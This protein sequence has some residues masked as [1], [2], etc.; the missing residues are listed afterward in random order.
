MLRLLSLKIKVEEENLEKKICEFLKINQRDL[1]H[2]NIIKKS[3]D[4]RRKD[5]IYFVY[6]L[7]VS[8]KNEKKVLNKVKKNLVKSPQVNYCLPPY[9]NKPLHHRPVIIGFGPSG[10]FAGLLLSQMGLKP[11]I[12]ERG[13]EV[14]S[15]INT[16]QNFWENRVLNPESNIQ[17]G[18]GG[19]GTFSD[20]KLNTRVK[21]LR[22]QYVLQAFVDHGANPDILTAYNPHIGTDV[23]VGV[24][25]NIR[26]KIISNGGEI[27][28]NSKLNDILIKNGKIQ[29]I[30]VNNETI[31]V[32]DLILAI[33]HSARDTF[34]MLYQKGIHIKQKAFA[35]G[36]RIEHP[37][38]LINKAQYGNK[39]C[40]Y[41]KLGAAEYKL[42]YHASNRKSVYTFCMCP[43]GMV[44]P[45]SSEENTVVVNGMSEYKRDQ[46][47]ANSALVCTVDSEDFEDDHPLSGMYFQQKLEEKAFH[48]GGNDY[49][50][51]IQL[52]DDFLKNRSS[53]KLGFVKP[54]YPIGYKFSNLN[55]L[56]S[57]NIAFA[58]REA[59]IELNKKL[60][61]FSLE[62]AVLTG[63]ETRT[64]SPIRI[65]RDVHNLESINVSGLYPT[66]EGAGYAGGITSSA[67]DGIK[68]AEK[69]IS[70]YR[71]DDKN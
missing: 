18:E 40:Q 35:V 13:E 5:Q 2:Y 62:D 12:F 53:I 44:V 47:N 48:L 15:R 8:L 27:Y 59:I 50:A 7:D 57:E 17:F 55:T 37:Q 28:F 61:G 66:G 43:G 56:F 71:L 41:P 19:A 30:V 68:V 25:K 63:V 1:I 64:S 29:E 14:N 21:D 23:L 16:I 45:S 11:I 36:V 39:Y 31:K 26:E 42:T 32:N 24:V 60:H 67:I 33:G 70:K 10:M 4:A 51:P 52:V 65:L 54:S 9:G 22:S 6:V 69:I 46:V 58:L 20:G 49:N 3:I 38:L 34:S